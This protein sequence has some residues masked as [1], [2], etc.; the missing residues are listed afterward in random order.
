MPQGT[1]RRVH[2]AGYMPQGAGALRPGGRRARGAGLPMVLPA[3]CDLAHQ[4]LQRCVAVHEGIV[5]H[6]TALQ[7]LSVQAP[8]HC[9]SSPAPELHLLHTED[10]D[11]GVLAAPPWL[12][13]RN[14]P[15]PTHP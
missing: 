6:D 9:S 12:G 4:Q 7:E 14:P 10:T 5:G 13:V 2:A 11:D 8:L 15:L 3:P 1:C